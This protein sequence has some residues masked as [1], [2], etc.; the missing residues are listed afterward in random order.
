V[1]RLNS[2]QRKQDMRAGLIAATVANHAFGRS[3]D[4]KI[5]NPTDFIGERKSL[6]A[7]EAIHR[8]TERFKE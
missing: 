4:A 7:R 5:L 2:M 8:F 1:K 6:P 3:P